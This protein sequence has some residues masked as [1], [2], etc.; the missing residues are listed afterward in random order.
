MISIKPK[1]LSQLPTASADNDPFLISQNGLRQTIGYIALLLP[2]LLMLS[3]PVLSSCFYGTISHYYYAGNIAGPVLVG[4][5]CFIGG[6]LWNSRGDPDSTRNEELVQALAVRAAGLLAI[7]IALVPAGEVGCAY[8]GETARVFASVAPNSENVLEVKANAPFLAFAWAPTIHFV[9]AAVMFALLAYFCVAVFPKIRPKR[10]Q[11]IAQEQGG[12]ALSPVKF[13]RNVTY[14]VCGA[15]IVAAI[16]LI[17]LQNLLKILGVA[18]GEGFTWW[19]PNRMSLVFET[20]GLWAF[21]VA[22]LTKGRALEIMKDP[23]ERGINPQ[24]N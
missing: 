5:L 9:A 17:G 13:W 6:C 18:D 14:Y 15:V 21:G 7:V 23:V 19:E 8:T 22:W 2:L 4:A 16:L 3:S 20:L 11:V 1:P 24:L 12:E 10:G